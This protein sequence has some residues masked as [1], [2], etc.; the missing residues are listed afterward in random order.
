MHIRSVPVRPNPERNF[1]QSNAETLRNPIRG[2]ANADTLFVPAKAPK[3]ADDRKS[4]LT[5]N[6]ILDPLNKT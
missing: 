6:P 2:S 4:M 5:A 3:R 1:A